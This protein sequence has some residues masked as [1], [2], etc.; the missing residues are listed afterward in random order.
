[1]TNDFI[2]WPSMSSWP[3]TGGNWGGS[4]HDHW[5][6]VPTYPT[7]YPLPTPREM[8][9]MRALYRVLIVDPQQ[10]EVLVDET[11]V[12]DDQDKAKLKA[13]RTGLLSGFDLDDLDI[14]VLYLMDV[15][16]KVKKAA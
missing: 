8:T 1:M 13:V 6:P 10:G 7:Y 15:R 12:A 2:G 14:G 5:S 9:S 11:L 16:P 3:N 4:S